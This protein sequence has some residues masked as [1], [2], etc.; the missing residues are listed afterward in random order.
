MAS[1]TWTADA[2]STWSTATNWSGSVI[3]DGAGFTANFTNNITAARTVTNTIGGAWSGTIGSFVFSDNGAAGSAWT[4]SGASTITLSN[5]GSG[6]SFNVITPTTISCVLAGS[7]SITKSGADSLTLSGVNTFGGSGKTVTVSAGIL[8]CGNNAGLGNASNT[9]TVNSGTTLQYTA[10]TPTSRTHTISGNGSTGSNGAIA[11]AQNVQGTVDLAA[12]STVICSAGMIRGTYNLNGY[13]LSIQCYNNGTQAHTISGN[14]N[15]VTF[16]INNA[17][18]AGISGSAQT[19]TASQVIVESI[20]G[21][22]NDYAIASRELGD[23]TNPVL[24]RSWGTI[25]NASNLAAT[26]DHNYTIQD[27]IFLA[28]VTSLT[29]NG[30]IQI[31]TGYDL[32]MTAGGTLTLNGVI[33]G[34]GGIQTS[35]VYTAPG[36]LVITNSANTFTGKFVVP[37]GTVTGSYDRSFGAIPAASTSDFFTLSGGTLNASGTVS[38]HANRGVLLSANTTF[39][40]ASPDILRIN[41][42]ISQNASGR[43][44]SKAGTGTL[45][46]AGS[47]TFS[48]TTTLSAGTLSLEN[49][50]ALGGNGGLTISVASTLDNASSGAVTLTSTNV[51]AMNAN[52][53]FAGTQNLKLGTGNVTTSASRTITVTAGDFEIQGAITT[54]TALNITK[55]GAGRFI[56]SS[57]NAMT[58]TAFAVNAGSYQVRNAGALPATAAAAWTVAD[59][60]ALEIG[61]S[62][63]TGSSVPTINIFGSGVSNN[64][65]LRF[66]DGTNTYSLPTTITGAS[67]SGATIGCESGTSTISVAVGATN[68]T[69]TLTLRPITSAKL[70]LSTTPAANVSALLQIGGGTVD[71][72][73]D[74]SS[75]SSYTVSTGTANVDTGG[76]V[77]GT[78]DAGTFNLLSTATSGGATVNSGGTAN[79]Y[80][81]TCTSTTVK[82]NGTFNCRSSTGS[83]THSGGINM[84]SSLVTAATFRIAKT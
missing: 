71:I 83:L 25:F 34:G 44:L 49:A 53:T 3:A 9:V 45:A 23:S 4:V 63:T 43:T 70:I 27:G 17:G 30:T 39:T 55:A 62:I 37:G 46:L 52:Y 33:S 57:T 75:K 11:N 56:H 51:F 50:S 61:N 47:N 60:A 67:P 65:A 24:L 19:Y 41:G 22:F 32:Y 48:G 6:S 59:G 2:S 28:N 12:N 64:G 31:D 26:S 21:A 42:A 1:G 29:L 40:I 69:A 82:A 5:S 81:G 79:I 84:G 72:K 76:K 54:A 38:L 7:E 18:N 77:T 35:S 73:C 13:S 74:L 78:V 14:G 20:A 36:D 15:V 10:T 58:G 16:T 8:V 68:P 80:L 66:V